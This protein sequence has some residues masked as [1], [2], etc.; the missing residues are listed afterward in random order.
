MYWNIALALSADSAAVQL[1]YWAVAA[2]LVVLLIFA[3][4]PDEVDGVVWAKTHTA[5]SVTA[6]ATAETLCANLVGWFTRTSP[7]WQVVRKS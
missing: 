1:K 7:L 4:Y 5:R 3:R 2:L 6:A